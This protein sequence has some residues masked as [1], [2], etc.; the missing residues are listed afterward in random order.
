MIADLTG[1]NPN[2]MYELG[3]AHAMNKEVIT[4]YEA[5]KDKDKDFK[6]PFDI[7]HIEIKIYKNN[8]TESEKLKKELEETID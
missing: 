1:L 8:I 6:F 3:Y 5:N 4:I 2:V 7:R